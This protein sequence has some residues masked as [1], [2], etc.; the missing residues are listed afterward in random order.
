MAY[1][2]FEQLR[3]VSIFMLVLVIF[4]GIFTSYP[5]SKF[6]KNKSKTALYFGMSNLVLFLSISFLLIGT[7][8]YIM[9][10]ERTILYELSLLI[11]M[12]FGT[13]LSSMFLFLFYS[14]I[15]I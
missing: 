6:S 9:G 2:N 3:L 14:D 8:D 5:F 11:G 10:E 1:V 4:L 13:I 7:W 15:N 12:R